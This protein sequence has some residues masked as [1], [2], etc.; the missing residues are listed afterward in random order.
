[1]KQLLLRQ[2]ESVFNKPGW[3]VPFTIATANLEEENAV[4]KEHADTNSI[5]EIVHHL[6]FYNNLYLQ[7]FKDEDFQF[8]RIS[9]DETFSNA[10]G[11]TWEQTRARAI[12]VFEEWHTMLR[13]TDDDKLN[14]SNKN[15]IQWHDILSDIILHNAYHIGQIVTIRKSR[16]WWDKETG[17][18]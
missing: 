11:S 4:W 13:E 14:A 7:R 6:I 18:S 2:L 16:K 9:N 12:I 10:N 8:V 15:G 3:F 5:S 1:M 17:V